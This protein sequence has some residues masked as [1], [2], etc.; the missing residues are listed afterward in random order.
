M[1]TYCIKF[2]VTLQEKYACMI[3]GLYNF[4]SFENISLSK[5]VKI[6]GDLLVSAQRLRSLRNIYRSLPATTRG[7]IFIISSEGPSCFPSTRIFRNNFIMHLRVGKC[8]N[9]FPLFTDCW[10]V[11]LA[12]YNKIHYLI[13]LLLLYMFLI[14]S[15]TS[16][17]LKNK[18]YQ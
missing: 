17:Y 4:F 6:V 16:D 11:Y 5:D 9:N 8:K 13:I 15:F 3:D 1:Y 10:N 7:H 2:W 12:L 14:P 18:K